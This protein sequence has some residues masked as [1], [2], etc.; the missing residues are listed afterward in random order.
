MKTISRFGIL[1]VFAIG[2]SLGN[3]AI[4][5]SASASVSKVGISISESA[6]KLVTSV[7]GSVSDSSSGGKEKALLKYREDVIAS[8]SLNIQYPDRTKEIES[9]IAYIAKEHGLVSWRNHPATFIAIGQGL[10]QA[11]ATKTDIRLV[12]ANVAKTN[13]KIAKLIEEGYN[14]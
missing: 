1:G 11:E 5:D 4:L 6:S 3:C 10:K 9:E 13:V 8:V 14:L 2:L 7:S 12:V